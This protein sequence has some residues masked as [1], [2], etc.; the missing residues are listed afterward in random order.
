MT[1]LSSVFEM[2]THFLF[3]LNTNGIADVHSKWRKR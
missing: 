1:N 3:S 2:E